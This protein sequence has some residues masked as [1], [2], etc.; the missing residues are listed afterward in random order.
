MTDVRKVSS[1]CLR[2]YTN[3]SSQYIWYTQYINET[4]LCNIRPVD[5]SRLSRLKYIIRSKLHHRSGINLSL[6]DVY[7]IVVPPTPTGKHYNYRHWYIN[8]CRCRG[9]MLWPMSPAYY[10]QMAVNLW[11]SKN[12]DRRILYYVPPTRA[13]GPLQSLR[14]TFCMNEVRRKQ[15]YSIEWELRWWFSACHCER[16]VSLYDAL[17]QNDILLPSAHNNQPLDY[18]RQSAWWYML[19][20]TYIL[21]NE[22]GDMSS[23]T[24]AMWQYEPRYAQITNENWVIFFNFTQQ[25]TLLQR[26]LWDERSLMDAWD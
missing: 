4:P 15:I 3:I 13:T 11:V 7:A 9:P 19:K 24:S 10:H 5:L 22:L 18:P 2:Y 20:Q 17:S 14:V 16:N 12:I 6:H 1:S 26:Y 25:S 23:C 8:E 21:Y